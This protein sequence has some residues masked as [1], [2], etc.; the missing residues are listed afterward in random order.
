M[1][2][3]KGCQSEQDHSGVQDG[4][5]VAVLVAVLVASVVVASVVVAS[6]V[7]ASLVG[8]SVVVDEDPVSSR[9]ESA[10]VE[11][12]PPHSPLTFTHS[13]FSIQVQ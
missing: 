1:V 9:F 5:V 11:V 7:V 4:V 10:A 12:K 13:P 6:V 8:A 3:G 2:S